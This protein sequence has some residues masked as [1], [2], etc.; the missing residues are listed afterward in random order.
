[1]R[2]KKHYLVHALISLISKEECV[3]DYIIVVRKYIF[4]LKNILLKMISNRYV[5]I[6]TTIHKTNSIF[7][8]IKK[9]LHKNK[10]HNNTTVTFY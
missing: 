3:T 6:C 10:I 8:L 5:N 4:V 1:M 2:V 9:W 7:P